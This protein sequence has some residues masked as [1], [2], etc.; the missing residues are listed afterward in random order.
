VIRYAAYMRLAAVVDTSR[1]VAETTKR[2]EKIDLLAQLLK[3][4]RP[5]EVETIVAFLTGRT[6]QGRI[7]IGY[8]TIRDAKGSP[9]PEANLEIADIDRAFDAVTKIQGSG[10]QRLRQELLSGLFARATETEQK[11][12]IGLLMGELRQ[13]ALEGIMVDAVAKAS[14]IPADRVRRAVMMAGDIAVVARDLIEKGEAGAHAYDVQLFRPVQPMLA[15][16]AEDVAEALESLGEAALEFK[17]DGARV[18]VHKS[19]DDVVVYSR[20]LNDV[21]AAVPEVLEAVRAIPAHDLILDG[22]VLSLLPDGRP[23]PFQITMRRFGRKLDVAR[24]RSELPMTPFWF[25]LLYL[26]GGSLLDEP[27]ARR[28][29]VLAELAPQS[30]IPHVLASTAVA[31]DEFFEQ[32]IGRGHEGIMAKATG[33]TYAAGAR[34]QSWLKIKKPRT[35]DLVILAAEWGHG[36]RHGRLSNLHLGARDTEKGGFAMLGKTF[37]GLTDEMLAWQ[38]QELL[39]LEIG[40]D[41]YTVH[42]EPKLVVEVAFNEIQVSPRYPSGLALRFARVKRYRPDKS[43][44]DSDTFQTVQ[45]MAGLG[46]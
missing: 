29:A 19:G 14:G 25:D 31:G 3:R 33:A 40:R 2:L 23:Q 22:E 46:A 27:Q 45:K 20:A 12:L 1:Q 15:Q 5:Q 43:T 26:N 9:A 10:S 38:T 36:R 42:V 35:L 16:T 30:L 24:M 11:F 21:S 6:R 18:Q 28:F 17:M 4:A 44:A 8:G 37:K 13:G 34:G 41:S 39:K 7:G 32:S